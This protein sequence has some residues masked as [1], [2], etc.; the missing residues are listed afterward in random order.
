MGGDLHG[1]GE[2]ARPVG[3]GKFVPTVAGL[4]KI[5]PGWDPGDG[6]VGLQFEQGFGEA[7]N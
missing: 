7:V 6:G 2:I 1:L 5:A 3:G 4:H